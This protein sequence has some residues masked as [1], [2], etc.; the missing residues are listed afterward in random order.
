MAEQDPIEGRGRLIERGWE[1]LHGSDS[2]GFVVRVGAII[3]VYVVLDRAIKVV[4]HLPPESYVQTYLGAEI[5]ARAL[6]LVGRHGL[7]SVG[8]LV[9]VCL[10]FAVAVGGPLSALGR[11]IGR[12]P[13]DGKRVR[14]FVTLVASLL[15]WIFS[16]YGYNFFFDRSHFADRLMIVALVPLIWARPVFVLP[17]LLQI[18]SVIGQF[19]I[20]LGGYSW[21]TP[22]L[23]ISLLTLFGAQLLVASISN[24][25]D[26]RDLVFLAVCATAAHY[27]VSGFTKVGLGW[28]SSDKVHLLLTNAY[29]HGWLAWVSEETISSAAALLAR[30]DVPIRVFTGMVELG[31][32]A[33]IWSRRALK[34]FILA[35]A[36]LHV[37]IFAVSGI[38]FWKWV[39]VEVALYLVFFR[40]NGPVSNIFTNHHRIVGVVLIGAGALIF[41]PTPLAWLDAP[42]T[43]TYRFEGIANSGRVYDL[44]PA[45]FEPYWYQ[46]SLSSFTYLSNEPRLPVV[47][48]ALRNPQAIQ[49]LEQASSRSDI[50]AIEQ[51]SGWMHRDTTKIA[52][53]QS[54]MKRYLRSTRVPRRPVTAWIS[55]PRDLWMF[56]RGE[57]F[58]RQEPLSRIRVNEVTSH[59]DGKTYR[60]VRRQTVAVYDVAVGGASDD[61]DR[62]DQDHDATDEEADATGDEDGGATRQ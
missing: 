15:A 52:G 41:R 7:A 2:A 26:R 37:G 18:S 21:A 62:H 50:E 54:L 14:I 22:S 57:T 55:P 43:Y 42:I 1:R 25:R 61:E 11:L 9:L 5:L 60:E 30:A 39:V 6:D 56:G 33:A 48:G 16:T 59:F 29:A 44:T 19:K 8:L 10:L 3:A 27:F 31:S 47:M 24:R 32:L 45:S 28:Y 40:S 36:M 35:W 23:P 58:R 34:W 53:M 4:A 12:W 17:F 46:F 51:S 13:S 20:P 38:C 49:L